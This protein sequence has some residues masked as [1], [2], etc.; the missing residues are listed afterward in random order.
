M[1]AAGAFGMEGMDG[2]ALERGDGVLDE[3]RLIERVGVDHH[4]HVVVVGDRQA[5]IDRCRG[6]SPVLVQLQRTGTAFDHLLKGCWAR[7]I[8]LPAK[9]RFTGNPSAAW[10]MRP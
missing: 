1:A 7:R 5:A 4:L 6:G 2:A 9:P 3:A 10:I 8:A